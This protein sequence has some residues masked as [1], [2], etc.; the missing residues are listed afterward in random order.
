M[1]VWNNRGLLVTMEGRGG[2]SSTPSYSHV[3][4]NKNKEAGSNHFKKPMEAGMERIC[5]E[6]PENN[7]SPKKEKNH[8]EVRGEE[9]TKRSS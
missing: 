8:E 4:M 6:K 7:S 9:R 5:T 1:R 2:G 3:V